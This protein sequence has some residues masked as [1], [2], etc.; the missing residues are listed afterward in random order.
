MLN[1]FKLMQ[2]NSHCHQHVSL[3]LD[4][5]G[6]H[7]KTQGLTK[8]R[9]S[10]LPNLT[11]RSDTDPCRMRPQVQGCLHISSKWT[12]LSYYLLMARHQWIHTITLTHHLKNTAAHAAPQPLH[13]ELPDYLEVFWHKTEPTGL[14]LLMNTA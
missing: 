2:S 12:F 5:Q 4:T 3:L 1:K 8:S 6:N 7:V 9:A 11:R 14:F 13:W 10:V